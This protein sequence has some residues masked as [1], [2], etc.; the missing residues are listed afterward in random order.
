[1]HIYFTLF[2]GRDCRIKEIN[3]RLTNTNESI[4]DQMKLVSINFKGFQYNHF[5]I[6]ICLLVYLFFNIICCRWYHIWSDDLISPSISASH[7][8]LVS[9]YIK[10]ND[11]N[12]YFSPL[13]FSEVIINDALFDPNLHATSFW[14]KIPY[15][16]NQA[17]LPAFILADVMSVPIKAPYVVLE[18]TGK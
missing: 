16:F 9:I 2:Q 10:V 3:Q 17:F 13:H 15:A 12:S 4:C 8:R 6:N 11:T 14:L 1:M 7:G 18:L 5:K